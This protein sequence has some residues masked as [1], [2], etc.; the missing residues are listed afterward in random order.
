MGF[1]S[2]DL[3]RLKNKAEVEM[4]VVGARLLN[5]RNLETFKNKI[6]GLFLLCFKKYL[7]LGQSLGPR[8]LKL[9]DPEN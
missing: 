6:P 4:I 9:C 5:L 3:E 1:T 2:G 7:A 8:T